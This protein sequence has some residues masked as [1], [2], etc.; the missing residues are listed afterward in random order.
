[1]QAILVA[2]LLAMN[3]ACIASDHGAEIARQ[4]CGTCHTGQSRPL[5]ELR[6]TRQQWQ[7]SVERMARYGARVPD[8]SLQELLDYLACAYG[9]ARPGAGPASS[10]RA[11]PQRRNNE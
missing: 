7:E 11:T 10:T 2:A 4:T 6:L 8:E 3:G 1:M 5:N 9:T